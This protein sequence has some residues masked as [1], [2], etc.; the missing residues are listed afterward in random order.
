MRDGVPGAMAA[1]KGTEVEKRWAETGRANLDPFA[2]VLLEHLVAVGRAAEQI[3]R[4]S[5]VDNMRGGGG[6][7]ME[8]S[9][10]REA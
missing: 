3:L 2:T 1:L 7:S 9:A 8:A 10:E 6:T 4:K 5:S